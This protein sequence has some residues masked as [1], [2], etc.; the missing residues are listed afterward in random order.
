[1]NCAS[2]KT[3]EMKQCNRPDSLKPQKPSQR[4]HYALR[5]AMQFRQ[6]GVETRACRQLQQDYT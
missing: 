4:S 3:P 1:M 2:T 6:I 5:L